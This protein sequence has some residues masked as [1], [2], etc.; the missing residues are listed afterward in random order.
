MLDHLHG[1]PA[2][3]DDVGVD[4]VHHLGAEKGCGALGVRVLLR[5]L[6][7]GHN[8]LVRP[9]TKGK[10]TTLQY[11]FHNGHTTKTYGKHDNS[12]HGPLKVI[13]TRIHL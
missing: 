8:D 6:P 3:L 13:T 9:A 12:V 7:I 10:N 4:D 11:Y 5:S 1:L 2:N